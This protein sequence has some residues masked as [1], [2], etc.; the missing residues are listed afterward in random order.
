MI[1]ARGGSPLASSTV[2]EGITCRVC[3]HDANDQPLPGLRVNVTYPF[4]DNAATEHYRQ[5]LTDD[6]GVALFPHVPSAPKRVLVDSSGGM[7]EVM[8]GGR[9]WGT[10]PSF[11]ADV[12]EAD[13]NG[14]TR[15]MAILARDGKSGWVYLAQPQRIDLKTGALQPESFSLIAD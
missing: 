1:W 11:A 13:G 7:P 6:D 4:A 2:H 10:A 9:S 12:D 8:L 15:G 3:L 14:T 5:A